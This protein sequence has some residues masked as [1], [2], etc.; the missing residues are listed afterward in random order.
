MANSF[1]QLGSTNSLPDG[2]YIMLASIAMKN[3]NWDFAIIGDSAI[4]ARTKKTFGSWGEEISITID[5]NIVTF[6]SSC[7]QWQI[8]DWGKNKKNIGHLINEINAVQSNFTE[9]QLEIESSNFVQQRKKENEDFNE[10]KAK[11][12]LSPLEKIHVNQSSN[13]ATYSIIAINVLIFLLMSFSGVSILKPLVKD[14]YNWGGNLGIATLHGQ[15]WR[16]FTSMFLHGGML[17]ILFNMYALLFIGIFLE[18]LLGKKLFLVVYFCTGLIAGLSSI[19][20]HDSK[21]SVGA[22]GA[23]FGLYGVFLAL[24][25]TKYIDK[26]SKSGLL[27]SILLFVF[28]SLLSGM[29]PGID[30]AAHVG[31]LLSGL[32]FGYTFYFFHSIK[33]GGNISILPISAITLVLILVGLIFIKPH[34][35]PDVNRPKGYVK[36][37]N[38][39]YS[40]NQALAVRVDFNKKTKEAKLKALEEIAE[41]AWE[42]C[43]IIVDSIAHSSSLFKSI[44][45]QKIGLMKRYYAARIAENRLWIDAIKHDSISTIELDN[46]RSVVNDKLDSM[47]H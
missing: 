32:I 41:P 35:L 7:I 24:L 8:I 27:R 28:Y 34:A 13:Y 10:R 18:P 45:F 29:K 11:G 6:R 46:I 2:T 19:Y 25:T 26:K 43:K 44:S 16:L 1:Q 37:N 15:W 17:H 36:T 31:G 14:L 39:R 3:L 9:E 4:I 5:D 20:W 22:S 42:N 12:L 33:K 23:I 47:N 38:F 30:N 40:E 21:V